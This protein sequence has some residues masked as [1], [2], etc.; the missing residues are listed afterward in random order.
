M[1]SSWVDISKSLQTSEINACFLKVYKVQEPLLKTPAVLHV[2]W[3]MPP[4]L[5]D[6]TLRKRHALPCSRYLR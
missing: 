4:E 6:I 3:Q 5:R 2:E 1:P